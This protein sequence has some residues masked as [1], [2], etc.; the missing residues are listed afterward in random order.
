MAFFSKYLYKI[1]S[2]QNNTVTIIRISTYLYVLLPYCSTFGKIRKETKALPCQT[3]KQRMN[4]W[5][6]CQKIQYRVHHNKP[7][8]LNWFL[9]AQKSYLVF[10]FINYAR[11]NKR[12][13][14]L[15]T[16]ASKNSTVLKMFQCV[17]STLHWSI[18]HQ[19]LT[20]SMI[21]T[22]SLIYWIEFLWVILKRI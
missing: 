20:M 21:Q 19:I 4:R 16:L 13:I 7:W 3:K 8:V 6:G 18:A 10:R 17:F 12:F 15:R 1:N 14:K 5:K 2:T 22:V 9:F 11:Y